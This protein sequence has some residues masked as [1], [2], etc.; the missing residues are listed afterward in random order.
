M[1]PR[2][3]IGNLAAAFGSMAADLKDHQDKLLSFARGFEAIIS[4]RTA[5]LAHEKAN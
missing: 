5:E 1:K 2:D 3:E 4:E